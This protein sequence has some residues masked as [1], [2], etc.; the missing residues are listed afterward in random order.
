MVSSIAASAPQGRFREPRPK[1]YRLSE[2]EASEFD[3]EIEV[4]QALQLDREHFAIPSGVERQLVVCDDI[5]A[6]F[7]FGEM[8]QTKCWNSFQPKQ[9]G[10]GEASMPGNDLASSHKDRIVEA[11]A[12]DRSC[13]LFDLALL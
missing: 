6:P 9:L 5:S 7:G 13:D 12:C 11:E 1:R 3:F 4:D 10:G 8:G 2:R